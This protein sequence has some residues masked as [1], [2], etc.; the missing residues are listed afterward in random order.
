MTREPEPSVAILLCTYNGEKYLAE[1]LDSIEAQ[2]FTN[3]VLWASDDGSSDQTLLILHNYQKKWGAERLKIIEGPRAGSTSNFMSL[4][5]NESIEADYYALSDQDDIWHSDKLQR[6]REWLSTLPR[7]APA[8][9]CTR[10]LLVD[11]SN[12][13]IGMSELFKRP[14]SFRNALTQNIAGGNTMVFNTGLRSRLGTVRPDVVIHDWWLYLVATACDG[15]VRYD[16]IPSLRYR[17]H[18]DN[19]IGMNIGLKARTNRVFQLLGGRYRAQA[20]RNLTALLTIDKGITDNNKLIIQQFRNIRNLPMVARVR[21]LLRLG[22]Y[23]Q[24]LIGN[25]GLFVG[26]TFNKI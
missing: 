2:S 5:Y 8:L 25:I 12:E 9:Y 7:S 1:Q 21:T 3:W 26:V 19:L 14:P 11:E 23:R 24:T 13:E 6:A 15:E 18:Q 22:L 17:Q 20:D 4:L 16:P 10:T